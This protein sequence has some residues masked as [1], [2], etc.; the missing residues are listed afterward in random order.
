MTKYSLKRQL[1]GEAL[2]GDLKYY[3][4][5]VQFLISDDPASVNQ[6]IDLAESLEF[7]RDVRYKSY[8]QFHVWTFKLEEGFREILMDAYYNHPGNRFLERNLYC[9]FN[10]NQP[11]DEEGFVDFSIKIG[12]KK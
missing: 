1:I 11:P 8:F 10:E 6:G 7:V 3:K 12:P 5:L 2:R 4:K 9:D